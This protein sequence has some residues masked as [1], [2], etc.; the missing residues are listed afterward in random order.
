MT[1][2]GWTIRLGILGAF[3]S[4][5]VLANTDGSVAAA[6]S[7]AQGGAV[8]TGVHAN[9]EFCRTIIRKV[10]LL[11]QFM[12]LDP[13]SPDTT[14]RAKY[15][16]DQKEL[17]AALVK[18]SPASI[19]ADVALQTRNANAS[20]D[21]Q[22]TRDPARIKGTL[23]PLRSPEHAAASKRMNDYCGTRAITPK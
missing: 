20:L 21:A 23:G 3:M 13:M 17:N 6:A 1:K 10:E 18:T 19:A 14:K 5:S 22:L 12:K 11:G 7:P 15:F 8:A 16:A 2:T 4:V 9:E